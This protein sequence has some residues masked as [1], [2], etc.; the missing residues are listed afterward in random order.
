MSK[1]AA[2]INFV[3]LV[4]IS[5]LDACFIE[6]MPENAKIYCFYTTFDIFPWTRIHYHNIEAHNDA[7]KY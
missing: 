4:T 3:T 7:E 6:K 2:N 5:N 1:S